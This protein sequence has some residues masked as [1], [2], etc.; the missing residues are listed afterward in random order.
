MNAKPKGVDPSHNICEMKRRGSVSNG[1]CK[2]PG[3]EELNE[4]NCAQWFQTNW[5]TQMAWL[6]KMLEA[7]KAE[8]TG[9]VAH[10]PN[11]FDESRIHPLIDSWGVDVLMAGHTHYQAMGQDNPFT[12]PP[13]RRSATCNPNSNQAPCDCPL[14]IIS[15]GGGGIASESIPNN[16]N[17]QYG[18]VDMTLTEST[19]TAKMVNQA[20]RDGPEIYPTWTIP[21]R[22]KRALGEVE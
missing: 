22:K 8:W 21:R 6:T 10:Y 5:K 2:G 16:G 3:Y 4:G 12:C 1:V 19:M 17:A 7:S 11:N 13:A 14:R 15:G 20:G 18:F 9:L